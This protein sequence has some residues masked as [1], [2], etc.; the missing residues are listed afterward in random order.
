RGTVLLMSRTGYTGH[1]PSV[2]WVGLPDGVKLYVEEYG[3]PDAELTV[4][5]LHGWTLDTRLWGRQIAALPERSATPLRIVAF[6]L[7][8]HGHSTSCPRDATTLYR[9]ADDL[10]AVLDERVPHGRAVLVGHSL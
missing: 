5:L 2:A 3:D 10:A 7:R 4:V 8:G 1:M 9:L 6:D